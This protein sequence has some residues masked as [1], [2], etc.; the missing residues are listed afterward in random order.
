MFGSTLD[1]FNNSTQFM[2]DADLN[3]IA[4]YLKSLPA[5]GAPTTPIRRESDTAATLEQADFS[6]P[7]SATYMTYCS[8][9]H[10]ANGGGRGGLLALLAAN[11]A[12]TGNDA[13]SLVNVILNG[14]PAPVV[15][16]IPGAYRMP[17]SRVILSDQE[18]ADVATFVRTGWGN[19][20]S[21]VT[22]KQVSALRGKTAKADIRSYTLPT[23]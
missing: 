19:D 4:Q 10:A 2:S 23:N 20:S 22:A 9:C 14:S 6:M 3:A 8:S 5:N 16:G 15:D 17:A 1:V 7:G 21:A 18:I 12:I 13:S 11:S